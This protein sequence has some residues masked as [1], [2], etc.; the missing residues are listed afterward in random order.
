MFKN[1]TGSD[2]KLI[3]V[4]SRFYWSGPI[5]EAYDNMKYKDE[6]IFTGHLPTEELRNILSSSLALTYISLFEG[7]G[8]PLVE[9]M[10]SETAILTSNKT[11]LPEIAKDAAVFVNPLSDSDIAQ[12]MRRLSENPE[13]R[14]QLI[15][16]GKKRREDFSW[17]KTA[18]KLWAAIEKTIEA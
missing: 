7:F 2:V 10:N 13:L 5:K 6:V 1:Q 16:N 4:G 9:A 3:I 11:C 12:G 18:E 15:E 17:D 14:K 8:I